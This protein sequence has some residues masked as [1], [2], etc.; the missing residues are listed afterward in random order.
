MAQ[1]NVRFWVSAHLSG[2]PGAFLGRAL[3][4]FGPCGMVLGLGIVRLSFRVVF[5]G[6]AWNSFP[7]GNPVPFIWEA[8][9][10]KYSSQTS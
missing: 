7:M 1:G 2:C 9:L 8:L 5:P 4:V 6:S 10:P 3:I